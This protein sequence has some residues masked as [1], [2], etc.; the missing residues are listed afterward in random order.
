MRED[1]VNIF[2]FCSAIFRKNFNAV[3]VIRQMAGSDH[4]TSVALELR[5]LGAH[6]ESWRGGHAKVKQLNP[7]TNGFFCKG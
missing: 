1:E 5:I 3:E 7:Q 4:D 6:E 2:M